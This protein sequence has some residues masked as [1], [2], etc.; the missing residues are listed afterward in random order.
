MY[1]VT[2]MDI[3]RGFQVYKELAFYCKVKWIINV[4]NEKRAANMEFIGKGKEARPN[5]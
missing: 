4:L 5:S 2:F 1:L 3:G